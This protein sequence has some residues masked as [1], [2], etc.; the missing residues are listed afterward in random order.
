[1]ALPRF[2]VALGVVDGVNVVFTT[3][4]PYVGGSVAVF[5]NGQLKRADFMDGWVETN[6]SLGV[7]TLLMA[8]EP[9]AFGNPDD[10]VQVFYLD[11]SSP[12]L[13][14]TEVTPLRGT[15]RATDDLEG[16]FVEFEPFFGSLLDDGVGLVGQVGGLEE[17]GGSI[18]AV[19]VLSGR[20]VECS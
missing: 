17:I 8:P 19:G 1:M 3:P 14:E 9:A 18:E 2:E 15:I 16:Q 4:T 20:M 6:P 5:L 7:V 11:S 12:V 10:V 13:P